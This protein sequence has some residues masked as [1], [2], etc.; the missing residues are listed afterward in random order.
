LGQAGWLSPSFRAFGFGS[1]GRIH[2]FLWR[3][4][5]AVGNAK[6]NCA[7]R[8]DKKPLRTELSTLEKFRFQANDSYPEG[9]RL[10]LCI[11]T[12]A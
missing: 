3:R 4:S 7:A 5:R 2:Q 9:I 6:R 1:A 12:G 8:G 10:L 11:S